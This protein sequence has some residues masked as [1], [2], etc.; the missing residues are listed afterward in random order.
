MFDFSTCK[1]TAQE[2][3]LALVAVDRVYRM[4]PDP[5]LDRR[6]RSTVESIVVDFLK[7]HFLQ[8]DRYFSHHAGVRKATPGTVTF[9][10][11]M[12]DDQ[13]DDLTILVL[14]KEMRMP[15]GEE[16][17]IIVDSR[18]SPPSWPGSSRRCRGRQGAT[19]TLQNQETP[20]STT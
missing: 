1:G 17:W 12:E 20:P 13:S 3:V 14:T 18:L 11:A 6:T 4:V 16:A 5:R 2:V 10:H 15:I 19:V 8:Y 9:T 7:K